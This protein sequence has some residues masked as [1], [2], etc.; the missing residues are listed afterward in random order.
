MQV[1]LEM[2]LKIHF[3]YFSHVPRDNKSHLQNVS[4]PKLKV[5]SFS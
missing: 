1:F 2:W 5:L 4:G 3:S